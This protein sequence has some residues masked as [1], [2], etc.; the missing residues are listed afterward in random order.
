MIGEP[1]QTSC[2]SPDRLISSGLLRC[3]RTVINSSASR[4]TVPGGRL[5]AP[6]STGSCAWIAVDAGQRPCR[7]RHDFQH[8]EARLLEEI[9]RAAVD[10]HAAADLV[11][12]AQF[13]VGVG[14]LPGER[15]EL[16][17]RPARRTWSRTMREQQARLALIAS[18][19]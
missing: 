12:Q 2:L 3:C 19:L 7:A 6:Y 1:A 16:G 9:A 10:P 17:S 4:C 5:S 14:Q 8:V 13:F 18:S 15:I 11:D